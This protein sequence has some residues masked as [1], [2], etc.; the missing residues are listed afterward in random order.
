MAKTDIWM[1][2]YIA[3]YLADTLHL[4]SEEHGAYL[5]LIFHA[6]MQGG[7]LPD[8]ER[9]LRAITKLDVQQWKT[10]WPVL[11]EFFTEQDGMLRHKR[12]DTELERAARNVEQKK[13]AGKASAEQRKRQRESN[14]RSTDD[15]TEMPTAQPT[16]SQRAPQRRGNSSPSPIPPSLK[17]ISS[18]AVLT[19]ESE[20]QTAAP[21]AETKK[22]ENSQGPTRAGSIAMFLRS[23]GIDTS[24]TRAEVFDWANEPRVTDEV[25]SEAV[26]M[27]KAKKPNERIQSAYLVWAVNELLSPKPK[28]ANGEPAWWTSEKGIETKAKETGC[29]PA[30]SGESYQQLSQRIREKLAEVSR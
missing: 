11:R 5:L 7:S 29:W 13:T 3:D 8:D 30:R 4:T 12:V 16:E 21:I 14:G 17:P 26:E 28:K 18:A 24:S 22:T 27:A 1:P 25:L 23:K 9:R 6:W 10:S 15:A 20:T 2:V 19:T